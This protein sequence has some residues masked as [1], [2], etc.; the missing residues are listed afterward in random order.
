MVNRIEDDIAEA[1]ASLKR[2]AEQQRLA[3]AAGSQSLPQKTRL[4]NETR[5]PSLEPPLFRAG[6]ANQGFE[7]LRAKGDQRMVPVAR[8][9]AAGR[10]GL[11]NANVIPGLGALAAAR[12]REFDMA[13]PDAAGDARTMQQGQAMRPTGFSPPGIAMDTRGGASSSTPFNADGTS[14][15]RYVRDDGARGQSAQPAQ[16]TQAPQSRQAPPGP[17][18]GAP[19]ARP[20]ARRTES[21][22]IAPPPGGAPRSTGAPRAQP[23]ASAPNA[24]RGTATPGE[25]E[26]QPR[27]RLDPARP[28]GPYLAGVTVRRREWGAERPNVGGMLDMDLR[29]VDEIIFHHTGNEVTPQQ[30]QNLHR[31]GQD[32]MGVVRDASAWVQGRSPPFRW[33]DVAY[34]F[35]IAEDGTIYDGR[36]ARYEGNSSTLGGANRNSI[37]VAFLGDYT[38]RPLTSQQLASARALGPW[39]ATEQRSRQLRVHHSR[40]LR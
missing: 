27:R 7:V 35:M 12:A 20:A 38:N 34:H 16:R 1:L 8:D 22:P 2:R 9:A 26:A 4:Q 21:P 32:D 30:V 19:P 25:N 36:S 11:P 33:D 29:E 37:A 39:V 6:G 31:R 14:L 24:Q 28:E 17:P 13:P 10:S 23:P 40:R 5:S 15:L 3:R 18:R